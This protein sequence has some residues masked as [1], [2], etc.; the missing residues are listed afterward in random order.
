MLKILR[1]GAPGF[2]V[3]NVASG[4]PWTLPEDAV[5]I[6]LISPSRPEELAVEQALGILLPT[7][8]EMAEI[9]ASSR[10]YSEDGATFMTATV[11]ARTEEET[12]ISA[13][14]TFVLAGQRLVT[15]RYLEPKSFTLFA[16][17]AERQPSLCPS[18]VV[19]F[20]GLID[21]IVD[22]MADVLERT[23]AEVEAN[24]R[25][26]FK[27]PRAGGFEPILTRLGRAQNVNA[28]VRDSPR[29]P[30]AADQLRH[31]GRAD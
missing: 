24:S 20:L 15:I 28:K 11:L 29:Q 12:P 3:P 16:S 10:L 21:A 22:R 14:I 17:Q 19:T 18:G 1:Q 8:E 27:Q 26:I 6:E 31:A 9:E 2:D 13:P 23:G 7:R 4:A 30:V 25:E 5:W